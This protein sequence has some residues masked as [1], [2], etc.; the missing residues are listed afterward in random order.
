MNWQEWMKHNLCP[1]ILDGI[2]NQAE[3]FLTK[4]VIGI[5]ALLLLYR[6]PMAQYQFLC[7][8]PN[9]VFS[10]R[11]RSSYLFAILLLRIWIGIIYNV[12]MDFG[13]PVLL[14][15][16]I[17][18]KLVFFNLLL[19]SCC[20]QQLPASP[21]R[22]NMMGVVVFTTSGEPKVKERRPP[23]LDRGRRQVINSSVR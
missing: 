14:W 12:N 23:D 18:R 21:D 7:S 5:N 8:S 20:K 16:T 19:S 2:W 17:Y 1:P 15:G 22:R 13:D 10:S 9:S 11:W 4:S 6:T 3:H